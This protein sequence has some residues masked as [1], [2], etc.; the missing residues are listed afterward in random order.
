MNGIQVIMI[1]YYHYPEDPIA[2][3]SIG[4]VY[5]AI[6]NGTIVAIKIQ[7]PNINVLSE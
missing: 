1:H 2:S 6:K 3:A 5:K 7:R 4:E